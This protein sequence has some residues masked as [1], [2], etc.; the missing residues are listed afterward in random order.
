MLKEKLYKHINS[1][2]RLM[3]PNFNVGTS[4]GLQDTIE[5]KWRH[6][7]RH[8]CFIPKEFKIDESKYK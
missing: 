1:K 8:W 6:P 7:Y 2:I 5:N 3:Y 4:T